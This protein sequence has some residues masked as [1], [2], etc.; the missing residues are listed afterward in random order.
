MEQEKTHRFGLTIDAVSDGI[1]A[2]DHEGRVTTINN[3]AKILLNIDQIPSSDITFANLLPSSSGMDVLSTCQPIVDRI[4]NIGNEIFVFN[5]IPIIINDEAGGGV[6]TFK[7]ASN[8]I[9]VESEIRRSLSKGLIAKYNV[10]DLIYKSDTMKKL[11]KKVR[12]FASTKST[13]IIMGETGT[14]KEILAQSIHNL[15]KRA[16]MPFVSINCAA[17]SEQLLESE[18][19]GYEEGAFTG[20]KKGGKPGLFETAHNGTVFLDEIGATSQRVQRHL[21][22]VLQEREVMRI[23]GDRIVP[24]NV[25][26]ISASNRA[27]MEEVSQ[28]RFREDLFFRLN[29]LSIHI[30]AL[31]ERPEDLPYLIERFMQILSQEYGRAPF[32]VP[33]NCVRKLKEYEW[34]GNVRQLK[35]FVE[36]LFL[37]CET[38]FNQNVFDELYLELINYS[39]KRLDNHDDLKFSYQKNRLT[40]KD[41][42]KE[43]ETIK[44]ALEASGFNKT[45]AAKLLGISRT[46]LWTRLKENHHQFG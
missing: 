40:E 34:P 11:I 27:L 37:I 36:R 3:K 17:L 2:F 46:T 25:R 33:D 30:P 42:K 8:V 12:Q 24:V 29:V 21:L 7:E 26:I 19:F 18:L 41:R 16:K 23:G 4:E 22:R 43:Y 38:K 32:E 13:V 39:P 44:N 28:G 5:H 9:E 1:I 10:S 6:S 20:S 14:G 31:R 35:N 45:K 15:S